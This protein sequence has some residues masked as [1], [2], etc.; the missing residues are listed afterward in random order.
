MPEIRKLLRL[1]PSVFAVSIPARYKKTLNLL[2]GD[3]V[4]ISLFDSRTLAV[5][6]HLKPEKI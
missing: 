6:R 1:T 5:R 4:E 3:Y 2:P